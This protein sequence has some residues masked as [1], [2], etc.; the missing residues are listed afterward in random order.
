MARYKARLVGRG[1]PQVDKKCFIDISAPVRAGQANAWPK[2]EQN[3]RWF[4]ARHRA[5]AI[6]YRS[7]SV[8]FQQRTG[9]DGLLVAVYVDRYIYRGS[10]GKAVACTKIIRRRFETKHP[11]SVSRVVGRYVL[12][13]CPNDAIAISEG[14][15]ICE[16]LKKH[17]IKECTSGPTPVEGK[18]YFVE[19]ETIFKPPEP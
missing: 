3:G 1:A 17:G 2:L 6:K 7:L 18:M 8:P 9:R 5:R 11:G 15:Y 12:R 16:V 10:Q 4:S 19:T 14:G 13:D